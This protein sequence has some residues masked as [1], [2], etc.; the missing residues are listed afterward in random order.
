[1]GLAP[2]NDL[3]Q[4]FLHFFAELVAY[5]YLW[6]PA[7]MSVKE[8]TPSGGSLLRILTIDDKRRG[9]GG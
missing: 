3:G 7:D 5:F 8:V 2:R 4:M 9:D 6:M 1:M